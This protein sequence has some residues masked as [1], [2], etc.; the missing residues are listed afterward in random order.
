MVEVVGVYCVGNVAVG[1][2]VRVAEEFDGGQSDLDFIDDL[3][4]EDYFNYESESTLATT[5]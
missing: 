1:S 5:N 4:V 3:I 2:G